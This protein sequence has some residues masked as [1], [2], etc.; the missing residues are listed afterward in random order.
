MRDEDSAIEDWISSQAAIDSSIMDSSLFR[1]DYSYGFFRSCRGSDE[2]VDT[3]P[4]EESFEGV[5][6]KAIFTL[7]TITS[8]VTL[9]VEPKMIVV[10]LPASVLAALLLSAAKRG[11][12]RRKRVG[13]IKPGEEIW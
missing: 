4:W 9:I 10:A 6:A 8:M 13:E 5:S 7:I 11:G 2:D 1:E 3:H 12:R